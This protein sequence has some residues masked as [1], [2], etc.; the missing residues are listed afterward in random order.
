MV[1]CLVGWWGD[2]LG[3][4]LFRLQCFSVW[5]VAI[6]PGGSPPYLH[7]SDEDLNGYNCNSTHETNSAH[8]VFARIIIV[9]IQRG[10]CANLMRMF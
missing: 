6:H 9:C 8:D 3:G 4:W 2:S 5:S 1:I 7:L 10:T